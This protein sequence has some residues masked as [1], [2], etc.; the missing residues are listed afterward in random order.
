MTNRELANEGCARYQ[1]STAAEPYTLPE[2]NITDVHL[3]LESLHLDH[4][5]GLHQ[6]P[7]LSLTDP[8]LDVDSLIRNCGVDSYIPDSDDA[9][10]D[11]QD[12]V[13]D[14]SDNRSSPG[15]SRS[16]TPPPKDQGRLPDLEAQPLA[17]PPTPYPLHNIAD[18]FDIQSDVEEFLVMTIFLLAYA[19]GPFLWGP[20]S[21]VFGRV[22]VLQSANMVFL[23]FNTVCGF[24]KTKQQMMAFRFLSGI[25]ASAPQAVGLPYHSRD[26]AS[27]DTLTIV[28]I[29]GGV[30]SDCFRADQRGRAIAVYSL[31]PFISPAIG[32]I[33]GGY[34]TQHTTW[35]W[36]FWMTSLFDMAVQILASA[37]LDETFPPVLLAKKAMAL[38]KQTGNEA[39]HTKWQGP[40]HSMKKI[41]MKSLVRP[42][43]MLGTQPAL[44][45]MAFVSRISIR[46]DVLGVRTR[47]QD[48]LKDND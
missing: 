41:L 19:V 42:F 20:L 48:L 4:N 12:S 46:V 2:L 18:E 15:S 30:L 1:S 44:Q 7:E 33:A 32:P 11:Y 35:R 14:P 13:A 31:I 37:F 45:A 21:E 28:Q 17:L 26:C 38:R 9:S 29:G 34:L 16:P 5:Q 23:L 22:K 47:Y 39:L 3:D 10:S 40:D 8:D 24:A 27:I 36:V 43:I 6:L 25:G